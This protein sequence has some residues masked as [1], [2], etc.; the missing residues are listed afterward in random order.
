M[1]NR[2]KGWL[3]TCMVLGFLFLY[4]PII[5]LVIYS[6]NDAPAGVVWNGFTLDW[7][8]SL[9]NN[10]QILN[11][12]SVSLQIAT[13]SATFAV[14]LGTMA[15]LVLTRFKRF[16]G[17][18]LF[19]LLSTA[20]L[21]MPEV[22]TGL[23][24]LLLFV[25]SQHA[26]GWPQGRGMST[27]IIGHT[28]LC[29]AYVAVIVRARLSEIDTSLEE[30]ALDLGAHP[31]TVFFKITLPIISPALLSGWLLAFALS[32]DDFV[33]ASFTTGPSAT[34]LPMVIFSKIVFGL[35]PEVNALATIMMTV[36]A[37]GVSI[38]GYFI[39]RRNFA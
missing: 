16:K 11:A 17:R 27:V 28:T 7:Y 31:L 4:A 37:I 29:M 38:A 6:F 8:S 34:T 14:V 39:N 26:F 22:I 36:V 5:L 20:P 21:V 10:T 19:G 1:R 2:P 9:L 18:S 13:T 24:L 15:A 30:A 32:M 35:T 23:G 33:I 25:S 12:A 3:L